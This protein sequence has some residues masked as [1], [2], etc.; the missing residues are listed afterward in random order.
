MFRNGLASSTGRRAFFHMASMLALAALT[1]CGGG[2]FNDGNAPANPST[3]SSTGP[4]IT[5]I[6]GKLT[7]TTNGA[8]VIG[9]SADFTITGKRLAGVSA[10][11]EEGNSCDVDPGVVATD[12]QV[13]FKCRPIYYVLSFKISN[14][15]AE[16][17]GP[18]KYA[19]E[20]KPVVTFTTTAGT[21]EVELDPQ[22]APETV[23]S[24]L[25]YA[26]DD[27]TGVDNG[28]HYV[29]TIFHQVI[30]GGTAPQVVRGGR[31]VSGMIEKAG[32]RTVTQKILDELNAPRTLSNT[33]G[34]IAMARSTSSLA[35]T[36]EFF[37]NLGNNS[38]AYDWK[39][40]SQPGYV[41][42]GHITSG[43]SVVNA[44]QAGAVN[45]GLTGGYS[46]VPTTPVTIT[47]LDVTP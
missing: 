22:S 29:N 1:A 27:G 6:S 37:F 33:D 2:D 5:S 28:E 47:G 36:S 23:R 12:T 7:G 31:F 21:I 11:G 20:G 40:T 45:A 46:N 41:V 39:S 13:T 24:F 19:L 42:I 10:V 43:R 3:P 38:A 16:S 34:T 30:N 4:E 17:A 32:A 14:G 44:I 18:V 25:T 8:V 26:Y 35:D 9:Q 15:S